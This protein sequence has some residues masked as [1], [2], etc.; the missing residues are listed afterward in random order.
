MRGIENPNR[1]EVTEENDNERVMN[2]SKKLGFN[3]LMDV[4]ESLRALKEQNS[5]M[6]RGAMLSIAEQMINERIEKPATTQKRLVETKTTESSYS[7]K[8]ESLIGGGLRGF[9]VDHE[10]RE[11]FRAYARPPK[12]NVKPPHKDIP[13]ETLRRPEMFSE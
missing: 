11:G 1:V 5:G 13:R 3:D 4:V 8:L 2:L 9:G 10:R 6:P 12:H 7:S